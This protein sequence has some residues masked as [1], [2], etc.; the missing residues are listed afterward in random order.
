[1]NIEDVEERLRAFIP[2]F[3]IDRSRIPF[4]GNSVSLAIP[5]TV[6]LLYLSLC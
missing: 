5:I 2:N 3:F 1:M 6:M 4:I